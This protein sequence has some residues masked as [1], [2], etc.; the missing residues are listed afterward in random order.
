MPAGILAVFGDCTPEGYEH[1]ERWYNREHLQERVGVPGFRFGRRYELVSGGDRRFFAFY[2]VESPAVLASPAYLARLNA[3]STWTTETMKIGFR[4][5]VRTVCDLRAAA[6]DL[7]GSHAVV[8]RA[9]GAMSPSAGAAELVRKM[10]GEPGIARVQ[11]WT[12]SAKQTPTDT[13]EMKTRAKDQLAAGALV[14]E[15]VRR[16]DADLVAA[17]LA[18]GAPDALGV[19]GPSTIGVYA[20]LCVYPGAN[21]LTTA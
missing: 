2:E 1:F 20:L 12:A 4:N 9:D 14:V 8:L 13:A 10:A 16:A 17:K 3:P 5:S 6:G 21:A 11:L 7:I 18:A 15:C 19:T